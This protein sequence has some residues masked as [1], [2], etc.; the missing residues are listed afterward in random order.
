MNGTW[1]TNCFTEKLLAQFKDKGP[2]HDIFV[3]QIKIQ[4]PQAKRFSY[5][6]QVGAIEKLVY[7]APTT[8]P[9]ILTNVSLPSRLDTSAAPTPPLLTEDTQS[10]RT[11]SLPSTNTSTVDG[12]IGDHKPNNGI[13]V[14]VVSTTTP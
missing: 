10:P 7:S 4:I 6:K 2:E 13:A 5:G 12:P 3:E 8:F 1:S 14:E 9:H 11:S